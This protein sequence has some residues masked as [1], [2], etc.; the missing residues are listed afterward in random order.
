MANHY[1]N[2]V[3][4]KPTG[5]GSKPFALLLTFTSAASVFARRLS[6]MVP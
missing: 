3:S 6:F 4:K 2:E 1:Q 5:R